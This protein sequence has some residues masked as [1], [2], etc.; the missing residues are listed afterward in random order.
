MIRLR[1]RTLAEERGYELKTFIAAMSSDL[2]MSTT[3]ARRVWF[4]SSDGTASS[5]LHH[6]DLDLL[7]RLADWLGTD[8]R[9]LLE[10]VD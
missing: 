1:V 2:G 3:S 6:L 9:D 4:S 5:R 10:R 7:E 8:F